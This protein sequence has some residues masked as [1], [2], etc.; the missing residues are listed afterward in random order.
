MGWGGGVLVGFEG[1][2]RQKK[3]DFWEGAAEK[4]L[5]ERG[6]GGRAK[7]WDKEV[8]WNF[9]KLMRNSPAFFTKY[10]HLLYAKT[11]PK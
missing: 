8:E 9:H 6:G 7:F 2:P 3:N 1:G 10:E 4:K 11:G 5:K